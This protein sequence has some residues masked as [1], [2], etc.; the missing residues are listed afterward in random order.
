MAISITAADVREAGDLDLETYPDPDLA[1]EIRQAEAI[2]NDEL[3]PYSDNTNRLEITAALLAAAYAAEDSGTTKS[4]SQA[5]ATVSFDTGEAL[6]LWRQAKQAD[7]TGKLAGRDQR[8]SSVWAS[9]VRG[10]K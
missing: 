9:N 2:V 7:P 10:I 5:S 3:A 4:I 8:K 1:F 6:S